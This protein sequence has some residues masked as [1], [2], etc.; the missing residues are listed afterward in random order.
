MQAKEFIIEVSLENLAKTPVKGGM[1]L[2]DALKQKMMQTGEAPMVQ[3]DIGLLELISAAD[4]TN[5]NS[6]TKWLAMQ[7][8][9]PESNFRVPEDV[10]QVK[11]D[12]TKFMKLARSKKL[13]QEQR[14]L[15]KYKSFSQLYDVLEQY[16]EEDVQSGK[17][18]KK[19]TKLEGI[20]TIIKEPG[21]QIYHTKTHDANCLVGKGTKWCTASKDD[22]GYFN[23]YS[24]Q[25]PLYAIIEGDGANQKKYQFH[26]ES[27]QFLN[28]R[29]ED[30]EPNDIA[31]LSKHPGW[32]EFL[33][34][35]I[36]EHYGQYFQEAA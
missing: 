34:M 20:D 27:D 1:T 28:A 10:N 21:L 22:D 4:P 9:N 19:Q 14:D 30:V 7:Y 11:Q 18:Q 26:Y 15:N 33:N 31:T 8:L 25:G 35:Q 13:P 32:A 2:T 3:N 23:Q 29:D 12:L 17:E 36:K 5:N 24:E 16:E 6:M